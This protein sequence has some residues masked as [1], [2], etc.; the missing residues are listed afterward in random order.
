VE[1]REIGYIQ[2]MNMILSGVIYHVSDESLCYGI[3]RTLFLKIRNIY[4]D[5]FK[6]C[7][8]HV[9]QLEALIKD[10]VYDLY[11]HLMELNV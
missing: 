4:L 7:Y 2:G 5:N 10:N 3:I 11:E 8:E 6:K 9:E 1:D